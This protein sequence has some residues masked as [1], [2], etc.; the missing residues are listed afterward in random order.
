MQ[1]TFK[2]V[3]FVLK[4]KNYSEADRILTLYTKHFGKVT[5][6]AKGVRKPKSRKRGSIEIFS[7]ISFQATNAKGFD[8]V[9]EV[10]HI[11]N[12][13]TVRK[14]IR[15]VALAYYFLE[16]VDKLT[17]DGEENTG[18]YMLLEEYFDRLKSTGKLRDLQESFSKDILVLLGY[19]PQGKKL[20]DSI[21]AIRQVSERDLSSVRVG[22]R[23]V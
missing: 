14:S 18:L 15:K 8:I 23:I 16:A 11:D 3:G 6:L 22:G 20:T 12:Y 10:Q 17:K 13:E 2:S 19:W 9:T 1:K 21:S 5:V 7:K 4:R